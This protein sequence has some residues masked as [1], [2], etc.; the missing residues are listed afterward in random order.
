M[1]LL[2]LIQTIQL[3]TLLHP[4]LPLFLAATRVAASTQQAGCS[5]LTRV[6][7]S[8]RDGNGDPQPDNPWVIFIQQNQECSTIIKL[9]PS[10]TTANPTSPDPLSPQAAPVGCQHATICFSIMSLCFFCLNDQ[11]IFF[12][13]YVRFISDVLV[14]AGSQPD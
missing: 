8:T 10:P 11:I 6:A 5:N 3:F 14:A 2:V 13:L 4:L 9:K 12:W 1:Y 7:G